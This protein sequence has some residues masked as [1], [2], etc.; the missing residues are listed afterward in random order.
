MDFNH[1]TSGAVQ[2]RMRLNTSN[3]KRITALPDNGALKA[4]KRVGLR[5]ITSTK[6]VLKVG[7]LG[8]RFYPF[9]IGL[10]G[11]LGENR[12]IALLLSVYLGTR[13]G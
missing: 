6:I 10:K 7:W 5:T 3:V 2:L 4:P 1:Q 11:L 8:L 12:G 13:W 9:L